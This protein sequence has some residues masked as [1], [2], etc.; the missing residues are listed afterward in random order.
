MTHARPARKG[1]RVA[2]AGSRR[3][4]RRVLG[5]PLVV[6]GVVYGIFITD[7]ILYASEPF[8]DHARLQPGTTDDR[9]ALWRAPPYGRGDTFFRWGMSDNGNQETGYSTEQVKTLPGWLPLYREL[10]VDLVRLFVG[11]RYFQPQGAGQLDTD[12]YMAGLIDGFAN[13]GYKIELSPWNAPF[14]GVTGGLWRFWGPNLYQ[15]MPPRAWG[16]PNGPYCAW[17]GEMHR[18]YPAITIWQIWNEPDY[19]HGSVSATW[20]PLLYRFW[21]GSAQQ[22]GELLAACT[23]AVHGWA[24]AS[25]AATGGVSTPT[26]LDAVL[27]VP[28]ATDFDVLDMH[29]ASGSGRPDPDSELD[30]LLRM[31]HE[32]IT[33]ADQHGI[34]HPRLS[35]SE[36]SFAYSPEGADA[37][38]DFVAKAY[39]TAVGLG[40]DHLSWFTINPRHNYW[41]TG[42]VDFG[43]DGRPGPPRPAFAAYRFDKAVL[44]PATPLGLSGDGLTVRSVDFTT[45]DGSPVFAAWSPEGRG[46]TVQW[47]TGTSPGE[48]Y[49]HVGTKVADVAPGETVPLTATLRYIVPAG[50]V[51]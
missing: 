29:F 2:P 16:D 23:E 27:A 5:P 45:G 4:W 13:A 20:N 3:R 37:Q 47:P 34:G 19:P 25:T 8:V 44:A 39:A 33:V 50:W 32:Q 21:R 41:D 38:A 10:D 43:T 17:L 15:Y 42:L 1:W 28:G 51:R 36:L 12:Y 31:A 49:D 46:G 30:R 11:W 48:V 35:V 18:R 7:A 26:Y 9:A 6:L 24:D 14:W 22:Y 40:W